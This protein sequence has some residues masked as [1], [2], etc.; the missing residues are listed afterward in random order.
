MSERTSASVIDEEAAAWATR[1]DA[2]EG[3]LTDDQELSAWLA[4]DPRRNGALLRAQAALSFLDRGRALAGAPPL[5][6]DTPRRPVSRRVLMAATGG[7]LAAGLG[8]FLI[9]NGRSTHYDTALGEV[10][11][12]PLSDGSVA[13]INTNSAI[14]VTLEPHGR[15][16]RLRR[17]EAWFDVVRDADRPFTV[18]AGDTRARALGTAFSVHRLNDGCE[19]LVTEG[20]V[21][22][23]REGHGAAV[24]QA[25]AGSRIFIG[26]DGRTQ[27]QA[28]PDLVDRALA[29]RAGQIILDG[30]TLQQAADMF[31]RYNARP[32]VIDDRTLAQERVVGL[33]R[34]N[35]PESFA[36]AAAATLGARVQ[37]REDAIRLSRVT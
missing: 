31:N 2:G 30:E 21:E 15:N 1:L 33:F 32:L 27:I 25:E 28:A 10:R 37:I 23:W 14:E 9:W 8:A 17:G 4:G 36:A 35:E 6:P 24:R 12:V 34:T 16:V 19:I 11:R 13:A 20:V 5:A 26:T 22:V 18:A 29:W 3:E 7:G